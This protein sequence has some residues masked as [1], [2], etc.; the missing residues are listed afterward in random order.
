MAKT[1]ENAAKTASDWRTVHG[2]M[3]DDEWELVA[4]LVD[5]DWQIGDIGRPVAFEVINRAKGPAAI[6]LQ[7]I[8]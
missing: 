8:D 5:S 3:T 2:D 6:R 4:D 1:K 7:F